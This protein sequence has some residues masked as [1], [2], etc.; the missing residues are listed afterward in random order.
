MLK[1]IAKIILIFFA[2]VIVVIIAKGYQGSVKYLPKDIIW[3]LLDIQELYDVH[4]RLPFKKLHSSTDEKVADISIEKN[5][6]SAMR[7]GTILRANVFRPRGKGKFPAIM[8]RVPYGKDGSYIYMPAVGKHFAHRGYA[9]ITQDV[10]GKWA[11][12]GKFEPMMNEINDGYDTIE[13]IIR[14]PW[15]DGT[16]GTFGE[17]Y[18][19]FTAMAAAASMH[20]ALKSYS[21]S[22]MDPDPFRAT[23]RGGAFQMQAMGYWCIYMDCKTEQNQ[24]RINPWHLPLISLA[25]TCDISSRFYTFLI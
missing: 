13:W 16:V 5:V 23:F 22:T 6:H 7:D 25:D 15:S 9:V 2:G 21:P 17:S 4:V 11:S 19:S 10:R 18:Y 3:E 20:P 12:D 1:S 8:V 14:Q 24:L